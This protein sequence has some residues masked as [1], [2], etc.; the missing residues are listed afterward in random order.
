[1]A[2]HCSI[3]R[4]SIL[5][6]PAFIE[7][8]EARSPFKAEV[9]VWDK[10]LSVYAGSAARAC[11]VSTARG[12]SSVMWAGNVDITE[13]R[14]VTQALEVEVEQRTRELASIL[15]VSRDLFCICG[16]DG[17]CQSVNPA[18][19]EA[20]GYSPEELVG[21]QCLTFIH[22]DDASRAGVEFEFLKRTGATQTDLRIR[23]Q[24]GSYRWYN[25]TGVTEGD[26]LYAAGR[27]ITA[28][29]ELEEALRQRQKMEAVGQL[30][31]GIAHDF[32][33]LLTGHQGSLELMQKRI[34][35]GRPRMSTAS[36]AAAITPR[37]GRRLTH[38]L[39]GVSRA[40]SRSTR[41][42]STPIRSSP[43]WKTS[44]RRTTG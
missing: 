7:A 11:P 25:W 32:N 2:S 20:L 9:R 13:A 41:S 21:F 22:P 39:L 4:T 42:R 36:S 12:T 6:T 26:V 24:D 14:L 10:D 19:T 37:S 15:R 44:L 27:D 17:Y 43:R 34:A 38:R 40:A 5:S 35:Q 30:T 3:R 8:L 31:G 18:W 1:M 29:K 28:R 23:A 33:N 16:L